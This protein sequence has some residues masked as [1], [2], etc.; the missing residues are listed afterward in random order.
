M[1]ILTDQDEMGAKHYQSMGD[2]ISDEMCLNIGPLFLFWWGEQ[3]IHETLLSNM[4][5]DSDADVLL[6]AEFESSF[7]F[8]PYIYMNDCVKITGVPAKRKAQ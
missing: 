8:I 7:I 1:T 4:I 5:K 6:D 2:E 3:P